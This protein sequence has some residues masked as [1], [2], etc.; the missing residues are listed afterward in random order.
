VPRALR[1]LSILLA[2]SV[3]LPGPAHGAPPACPP[4]GEPPRSGA[5]PFEDEDPDEPQ[6]SDAPADDGTG[7]GDDEPDKASSPAD[8]EDEEEAQA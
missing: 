4:G 1:K 7:D 8:G 3:L 6:P 2:I 5:S